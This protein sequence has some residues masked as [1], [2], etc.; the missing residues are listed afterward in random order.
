MNLV[1]Q[2]VGIGIHGRDDAK[3]TRLGHGR[4]Q[5]GIGN[6]GHA[7][8]KHGLLDAEQ[9]AERS[10]EHY[11]F[12]NAASTVSTNSPTVLGFSSVSS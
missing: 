8:L 12:S 7:A 5:R 1:A 11:Y 2:P 9:V 10:L 4:R 3:A 6:P